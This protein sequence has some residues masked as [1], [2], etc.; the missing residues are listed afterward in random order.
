MIK[1][2]LKAGYP[3]LAAR[4][5]EPE[6]TQDALT[7]EIMDDGN[8]YTCYTW[9]ILKGVSQLAFNDEGFLCQQQVSNEHPLRW[10]DGQP[11]NIVLFL[12]NYHRC[13]G[14]IENVQLLQDGRDTW[15]ENFRHIVMLV[16]EIT[17]PKEIEKSVTIIDFGLPGKDELLKVINTSIEGIKANGGEITHKEEDNEVLINAARGMTQ[18]EAENAFALSAVISKRFNPDIIAEHK[19][20]IIKKSG[21]MELYPSV[22][23]SELGGLDNYKEYIYSRKKGFYDPTIPALA[24]PKGV[25]LFGLPGGGKSLSAKVT[26]SVLGFPLI[27]LDI[28]NLKG[29]RVGES[30]QNTRHAWK[31]IKAVAPVV[32]WCEEIEK[33]FGGVKSSGKSDAGTTSS[34][35]GL[36]L[37]EMQECT[38]PVFFVMT[39][40]DIE[41]LFSISQGALMRRFDD[42]IFFVDL[43][44][45]EERRAIL[46]IMNRRYKSHHDIDLAGHMEGWTGAEIEKFVKNSIYD[47]N[48]KAFQNIKPIYHQNRTAIEATQKWAQ[49][50]AIY[51]NKTTPDTRKYTRSIKAGKHTLN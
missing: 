50:N 3:I 25:L 41:E 40:N 43:P 26:A 18:F 8:H 30:E 15:K 22:P 35:F 4:T 2:Y 9:N 37:T 17:L 14:S 5:C 24:R 34:M 45:P 42:G 48:Q 32:V 7:R 39:C 33:V 27:R 38:E 28:A 16:P 13:L 47:G 20:Q 6:R 1:E 21:F 10:L 44:S 23:E 11:Q 49:G 36:F 46:S 29:S 12:W 51:A 31:T 19:L